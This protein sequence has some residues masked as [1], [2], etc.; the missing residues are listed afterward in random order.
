MKRIPLRITTLS[1]ALAAL[2]TSFFAFADE[3]VDLNSLAVDLK[4]AVAAGELSEDEAV[5]KYFEAAGEQKGNSKPASKDK[6]PA[7]KSKRRGKAE[8]AMTKFVWELLQAVEKDELT[9]AEAMEKYK[10]ALADKGDNDQGKGKKQ[11]PQ[12]LQKLKELGKTLPKTSTAGDKE[13][14]V[15]TFIFGIPR[16]GVLLISYQPSIDHSS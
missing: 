3:K 12:N 16:D 9:A 1:V 14:P 8:D 6:A 7:E 5:A 4:K 10:Y 11:A 2:A 15:S 13:G